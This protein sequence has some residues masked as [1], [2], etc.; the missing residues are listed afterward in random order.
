MFKKDFFLRIKNVQLKY[1]SSKA[2]INNTDYIINDNIMIMII[3]ITII[4]II[5]KIIITII[6]MMIKLCWGSTNYSVAQR[7]IRSVYA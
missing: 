5:K 4:V 6:K 2:Q 3:M 1:V 7:I